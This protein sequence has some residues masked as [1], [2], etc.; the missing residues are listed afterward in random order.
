VN[1]GFVNVEPPVRRSRRPWRFGWTEFKFARVRVEP[2]GV[3]INEMSREI[4]EKI[5]PW[6]VL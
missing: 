2:V 6:D 1:T 4:A 3:F 5:G